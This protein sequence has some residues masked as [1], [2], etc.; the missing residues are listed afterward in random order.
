[1]TKPFFFLIDFEQQKPQ[2]IPLN[3]AAKC[4]VFFDILGNTNVDWQCDLPTALFYLQKNPMPYEQYR[5]GFKIVQQNLHFGNTYLL[6]LTYPTPIST[7]YNLQQI[8]QKTTAP[9]KLLFKNE[10][11]CFSPECFVKMTGNH[12]YT[13][14]MKGT[15]DADLPNAYEQLINSTKEQWEHNT[16]VDLMRNDLAMTAKNIEVTKFRYIDKINTENGSILQTSSEIRGE[17]PEN[18]RNDPLSFILPLLP[19]G[20]ISGA[21]KEKTVQIIRQAEQ[22]ARGYYSGIFGIFDGE[23]LYSAVAIRYIEQTAQGLQFRSGGGITAQSQ[24][25]AEY[26]EL[27]QKVYVPII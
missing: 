5:Q 18:W 3:E 17:L 16:I 25:E 4:G 12:I 20:S 24:C 13:Y 11:V 8:F 22:Q 21:P 27:L 10:F 15:I 1:M 19:A 2:I 23:N 6:N 9:Y 14:P 7:N 26:Q